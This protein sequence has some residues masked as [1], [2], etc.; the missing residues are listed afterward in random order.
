[1]FQIKCVLIY[2]KL[3]KFLAK[4]GLLIENV[5]FVFY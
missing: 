4:S 3:D 5:N 2:T 1:M